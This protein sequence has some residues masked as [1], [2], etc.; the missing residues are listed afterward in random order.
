MV[1]F[2]EHWE[3]GEGEAKTGNSSLDLVETGLAWLQ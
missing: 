2:F 3:E 1:D